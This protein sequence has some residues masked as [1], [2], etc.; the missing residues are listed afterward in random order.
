MYRPVPQTPSPLIVF[1][2]CLLSFMILMA[3]LASVGAAIR[4][5]TLPASAN[6]HKATEKVQPSIVEPAALP[7]P[8]PLP[9]PLAPLTLTLIVNNTG[10]APDLILNNICDTG[11]GQ[12]TLRAAIE[13]SNFA[14][15][16]ES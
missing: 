11:G 2:A 3:P 5:T 7:A 8:A 16:S 14:A 15:P 9:A 13:E 4:R 6:N 10:D 1:N 12:C